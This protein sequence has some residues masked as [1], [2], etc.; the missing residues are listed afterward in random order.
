MTVHSRGIS[1]PRL[2]SV[3]ALAKALP[4]TESSPDPKTS[5][6]YQVGTVELLPSNVMFFAADD[7]PCAKD[8]YRVQSIKLLTSAGSITLPP[9]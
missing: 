8:G 7:L 3:T 5:I 6:W 4:F 9:R 1:A 2:A